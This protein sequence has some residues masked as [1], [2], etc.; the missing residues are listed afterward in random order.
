VSCEAER[1]VLP[2]PDRP[3]DGP[4][5]E[6]AKDPAATSRRSVRCACGRAERAGRPARR[7]GLGCSSAFGGPCATPT[8]ERLARGG[9]KF[10]RFHIPRGQPLDGHVEWVQIDIAEAA[11]D[12]DHQITPDERLKIAMN[13]Q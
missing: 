13:R 3:D 4:I 12:L 7:R 2:I 10:S 6:D 9:L 11:Q 8:A 1:E 5:H